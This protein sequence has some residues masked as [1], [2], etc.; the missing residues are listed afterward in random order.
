LTTS[1]Q[2]VT[3]TYTAA[4]PGSSTIDFS[5]YVSSAAPGPCAYLDDAAIFLS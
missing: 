1:W 2:Q 5:A 3:V 4:A